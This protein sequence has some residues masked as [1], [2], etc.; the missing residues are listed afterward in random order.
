MSGG[1]VGVVGPGEASG[2][3]LDVAEE[4]GRG[5]AARGHVVL[6]GGLGGVMGAVA[7]G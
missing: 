4:V 7:R 3:D 5:L 2:V 6:C 1:H